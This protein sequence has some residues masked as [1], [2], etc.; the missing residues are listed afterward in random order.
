MT[1]RIVICIDLD[2]D[3]IEL[4]Y[5]ELY[6]KMGVADL[7]WESSDEWYYDDGKDIPEFI[8]SEARMRVL[9][10]IQRKKDLG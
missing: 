8:I 9:D 6:E 2:T 5:R 7:E 3:N 1:T 4:A 10:A